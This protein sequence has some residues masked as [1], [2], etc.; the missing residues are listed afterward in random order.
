M[1]IS[2]G[3]R[4]YPKFFKPSISWSSDTLSTSLQRRTNSLNA[5]SSMSTH[6]QILTPLL[7]K[8]P[9]CPVSCLHGAP[10]S[11]QRW[12][13]DKNIFFP[14]RSCTVAAGLETLQYLVS[15]SAME[16]T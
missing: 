13:S 12:V 16:M 8:P 2:S 6:M 15:N 5:C 3:R 14:F 4:R 1:D 7:T 10:A 9:R 11:L